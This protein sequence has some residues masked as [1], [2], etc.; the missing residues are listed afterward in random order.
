MWTIPAM[1]F[2]NVTKQ[3][4]RA[5]VGKSTGRLAIHHEQRQLLLRESLREALKK[6]SSKVLTHHA[7]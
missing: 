5:S 6:V 4:G 3:N 2:F 1:M 7:M